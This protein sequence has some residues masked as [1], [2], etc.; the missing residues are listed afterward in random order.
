VKVELPPAHIV[1]VPA[2]LGVGNAFTVKVLLS[3]AVQPA[4]LVTVTVYV[5]AVDTVI[6]AVVALVLHT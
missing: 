1:L 3:V 4:A 5:A 2:M 6:A